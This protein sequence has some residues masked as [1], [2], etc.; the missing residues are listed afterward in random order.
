M[1]QSLRA[2]AVR[3]LGLRGFFARHRWLVLTFAV[4]ISVPLLVALALR[5]QHVLDG[6]GDSPVERNEHVVA[7]LRGESLVPPAGF[8]PEVFTT[9]E[10][11]LIRPRLSDANRDWQRLDPEF[12]QRLLVAFRVMKERYG[13]DMVLIEGYRSPTRQDALAA[14]GTHVTQARAYQSL[15]QYGLAADAAFFRDGRLVIADDDPWTRQGYELYGHV[16]ELSGLSWGGRWKMRDLSHVELRG[17]GIA[18][19]SR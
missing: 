12:R 13:Y 18:T 19:Q 5:E 1:V 7:L 4:L 14:M 17:A 16:A 9:R 15:H 8:P 11:E 6:F 10:V 2:C 3:V